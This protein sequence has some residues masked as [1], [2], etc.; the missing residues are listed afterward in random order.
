MKHHLYIP[1]LFPLSV[2]TNRA[3][4]KQTAFGRLWVFA[5]SDKGQIPDIY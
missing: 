1:G 5:F 3:F 4:R 2:N